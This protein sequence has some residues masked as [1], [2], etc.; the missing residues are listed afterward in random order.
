MNQDIVDKCIAACE[1]EDLDAIVA[2]SPENFAYVVGFIVPSQPVLRWR[3]AA[4]V[5]TRD[6]RRALLTVDMEAT[7]VK[8]LQPDEDVRVWAEF[9]ENAMPVFADLLGDLGLG[10]ARVGLETDYLPVRDME[11]LTGLLPDVRW[12]P[13]YPIF[14]RL[15]M[16]KTPRELEKMRALARITDRSI[17]EALEGV[18][19]GDT[20]MDL[21]GAVTTNLF[22]Y[23]AQNFKWLIL[24][25]GE[26]SQFPNVGPTL[27]TL[28]RGDI[29]RLEVF[30]ALDGYHTGICRTAVVQEA[31]E[32]V[33]EIWSNIVACRDVIFG[34][35]RDGASATE[36]HAK[37]MA[38]FDE[39]EWPRMD[40]VGHGIGMFVHEDP[41]LGPDQDA[42]LQSGMVL[43]VE[44]V[45]LVP[46]KYGFQVK[47][48]VAVGASGCEVLSD[49]TNTDHLLVIE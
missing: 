6:G 21:A 15:R 13:C 37:V 9:Q 28:E 14:N 36:V 26:R 19:A 46:G 33:E 18:H 4:V 23:G 8:N 48:I 22:R 17:K 16:L 30:G 3:H 2:M 27:R 41:Y 25:S 47:D 39:L 44:P 1:E 29:V 40:F 12:E 24:A 7:T 20:E 10:S 32:G 43:G 11:R 45:L 42:R 38:R 31:P 35:V 49:V 34:S 5:I